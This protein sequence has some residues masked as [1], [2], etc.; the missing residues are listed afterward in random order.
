MFYNTP[1]YSKHNTFQSASHKLVLY[2]VELKRGRD[3]IFRLLNWELKRLRGNQDSLWDKRNLN[4]KITLVLSNGAEFGWEQS[5]CGNGYPVL[6]LSAF[7]GN[8]VLAVSERVSLAFISLHLC[9]CSCITLCRLQFTDNY[10]QVQV[11]STSALY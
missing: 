7:S 9:C 6:Y 3:G 2:H 11:Y 10:R 5:C 4:W 8:H 1:R